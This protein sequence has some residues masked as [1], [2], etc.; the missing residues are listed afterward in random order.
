MREARRERRL[1]EIARQQLAIEEDRRNRNWN[2]RTG[3]EEQIGPRTADL[4]AMAL[5]E[6]RREELIAEA[7]KTGVSPKTIVKKKAKTEKK[8]EAAK[9]KSKK[10][11]TDVHN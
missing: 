7:A 8:R 10:K 9:E 1:R 5:R 3:S 4:R 2:D 6:T 11:N